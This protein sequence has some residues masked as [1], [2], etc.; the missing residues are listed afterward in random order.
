MNSRAAVVLL[1]IIISTTAMAQRDTTLTKPSWFMTIDGGLLFAR[2]A[3]ESAP[4][5]HMRQGVRYDRFALSAGVGYDS[6]THWGSLPLFTGVSFDFVQRPAHA[7]YLQMDI[8]YSPTWYR[9]KKMESLP[10]RDAG[11]YFYHPVIGYRG[12]VGRVQI[13]M[14]AGYKIQ[15]IEWREAQGGWGWRP[16]FSEVTIAQRM[17]RLS[18]LIGIGLR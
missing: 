4:S 6:Y 5:I 18:F 9:R 8:G 1:I 12:G 10:L 15:N 16:S 14:S 3:N 17:Q 11:G 13:H 7:F 2:K